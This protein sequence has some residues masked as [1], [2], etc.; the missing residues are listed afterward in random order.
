MLSYHAVQAIMSGSAQLD[1]G[2][3]SGKRQSRG[4]NRGSR[5]KVET[6]SRGS[7]GL[8]WD[9]PGPT[10]RPERKKKVSDAT[11]EDPK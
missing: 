5:W 6:K 7:P 8:G 2:F 1:R 11:T 9:T 3:E 10:D 4:F